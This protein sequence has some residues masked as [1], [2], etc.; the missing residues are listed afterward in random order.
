MQFSL[1]FETK[2]VVPIK[3]GMVTYRIAN[4]DSKKNEESLITNLD[5]LEEKRDEATLRTIAYK[6]KMTKYYNARVKT[7]RFSI[8]ELVLRKV[9]LSTQNLTEGK[10]RPSWEGPY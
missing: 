6:Q 10:L 3:I 8:R 9:S 7:K 2:A 1:A 4:F 5:L